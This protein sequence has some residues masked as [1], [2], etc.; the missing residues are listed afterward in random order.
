[1][2]SNLRAFSISAGL[3]AILCLV[4][5]NPDTGHAEQPPPPCH[6]NPNEATDVSTAAIRADVASLPMP[7]KNR[8]LQLASRPHTYLPQQAFAE[9]TT[10]SLLFQ[11]YLLDTHGFEPNVFTSVIPG[12]N[13]TAMKAATGS[14]CGLPALAAVRLVVEPK[15]GLPTDP[16]DV[17]AFIDVFTDISGLFVINNERGWYE[18]WMIHDLV[19]PAVA[20]PRPDGHAQFGTITAE[21]AAK[22]A[23]MGTGNN[24]P[25]NVF[26]VDGNAPRIPSENDHFPTVQANVAPI[27]LS[28]GA[29]N[30]LQQ[31]DCHAYW[32]FNYTTNWVHPLY[33]LPF[34]GGFPAKPGAAPDA[35]AHGD[36]GALQSIVPG[37]GPAGKENKAN[38]YGDDPNR[39]R[40]PD[41]FE[42][43]DDAQREFRQRF[44]PSGLA[45]E[46]LLDVYARPA[47]FR[48][49]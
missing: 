20:P 32:E 48:P 41:L 9:A 17:R 27:H 22:L 8:L 45:R 49:D 33:E 14:N 43:D 38:V 39:P 26:T 6:L 47:S 15:P 25:G 44:I 28:M 11:Y 12:V 19:V 46:I 30:C 5:L 23:A 3:V 37:S 1:M 16:A 21:D 4:P 42:A 2:T 35:F 36:I 10:S 29:Y 13:D 40:D 24:K 18:G 34:T 7:L 31:T